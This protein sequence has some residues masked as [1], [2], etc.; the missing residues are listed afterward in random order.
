MAR[1]NMKIPDLVGTVYKGFEILDYKR[2][3][4]RSLILV[5]C[6][7]CGKE[8]WKPKNVKYTFTQVARFPTKCL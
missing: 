8:V 1:K 6:P 4:G 5:K 2:E 7:L 3:N